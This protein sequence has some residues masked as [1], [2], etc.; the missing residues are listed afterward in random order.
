MRAYEKELS[1]PLEKKE[2][3]LLRHLSDQVASKLE[4]GE[5]PIKFVISE[6]RKRIPM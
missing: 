1:I 5:V 2:D 6:K 3:K 4:V